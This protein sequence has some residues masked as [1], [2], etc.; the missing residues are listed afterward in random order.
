[1]NIFY[2]LVNIYLLSELHSTLD[3][4]LNIVYANAIKE[5]Q[6]VEKNSV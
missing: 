1:M 5:E 4:I 3:L 2:F 6:R